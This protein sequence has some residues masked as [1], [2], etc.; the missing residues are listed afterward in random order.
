MRCASALLVCQGPQVDELLP[1]TTYSS[2]IPWLQAEVLLSF[3]VLAAD[4]PPLARPSLALVP[5]VEPKGKRTVEA[6]LPLELWVCSFPQL[7]PWQR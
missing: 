5:P 7:V 2:R 6:S 1:L 3:A 4:L